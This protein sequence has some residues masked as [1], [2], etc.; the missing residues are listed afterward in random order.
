MLSDSPDV[1]ARYFQ[2]DADRDVDG[3]TPST[4]SS[5]PG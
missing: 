1:I 5:R 2:L 4:T 3:I